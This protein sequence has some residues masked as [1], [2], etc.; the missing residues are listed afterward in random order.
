[1]EGS[2]KIVVQERKTIPD[3][4]K[5]HIFVCSGGRCTICNIDTLKDFRTGK[6]KKIGEFA[7][8]VA[9]SDLG[10]RANPLL[11]EEE[12][13]STDNLMLLCPNC[14]ST[15]D[16][17]IEEE[18]YSV[19]WLKRKKRMHEEK[20][21]KMLDSLDTAYCRFIKYLS[22]I[23]ER[24]FTLSDSVIMRVAYENQLYSRHNIINLCENGN[25]ESIE[26][27]LKK[28]DR[29]FK[30]R[31]QTLID[32]NDSEPICLFAVAPQPLLIYLG[33]K[34]HDLME[35]KI[36]TR[37]HNAQWV[38]DDKEKEPIS[39]SVDFPE[40]INRDNEVLL[41]LE[42]TN[43]VTK[44]RVENTFGKNVDIWRI[45]SECKGIDRIGN[46][47]EISKFESLCAEVIDM[48]GNAYGR[49]KEINLL[50]VVC[51]SL[52]IA[53]GR[54][55]MPKAQTIIRIY[56]STIVSG[57]MTDAYSFTLYNGRWKVDS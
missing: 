48:I 14:H 37:L 26:E 43:V 10:E 56:D 7:H 2:V 21:E 22:P 42:C 52:A 36:F 29:D 19:D 45:S 17:K 49:D 18:E 47:N 30:N 39:F 32:N 46:Q 51:N 50:P 28:I 38:L 25:E 12:R 27:S 8:M 54:A 31:V 6:T 4:V 13:N 40:Q 16:K 33:S 55:I 53:F 35:V 9:F 23:G 34:F 5:I 1:V 20:V 24:G 3:A 11:T 41:I 57:E 15:I 44:E